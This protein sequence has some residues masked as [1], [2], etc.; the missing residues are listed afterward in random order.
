MSIQVKRAIV[1]VMLSGFLLAVS[2]SVASSQTAPESQ[3]QREKAA[4]KLISVPPKPAPGASEAISVPTST[5]T[6]LKRTRDRPLQDVVRAYDAAAI[7]GNTLEMIRAL[8]NGAK[9]CH[10]LGL[11][12]SSWNSNFG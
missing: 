11:H 5:L 10:R 12:T 3:R 7:S 6:A 1:C 4:C 2:G 9:V 8:A